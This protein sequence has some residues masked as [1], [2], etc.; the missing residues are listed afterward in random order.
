MV[1]GY[2][3]TA[4]G[5]TPPAAQTARWGHLRDS[6]KF[7]GTVTQTRAAELLRRLPDDDPLSRRSAVGVASATRPILE[8][9]IIAQSSCED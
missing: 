5:G 1:V 7:I 2:A 8:K 9:P 4:E 3:A 6:D